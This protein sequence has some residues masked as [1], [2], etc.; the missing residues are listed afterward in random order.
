MVLIRLDAGAVPSRAAVSSSLAEGMSVV[1]SGL[2]PCWV[3]EVPNLDDRSALALSAVQELAR[4]AARR[5]GCFAPFF[6]AAAARAHAGLPLRG[7]FPIET[8][9]EQLARI[10]SLAYSPAE[11]GFL[12]PVEPA[13]ESETVAV[14]AW[15]CSLTGRCVVLCGAPGGSPYESFPTWPG[16]PAS[17]APDDGEG[18]GPVAAPPVRGYPHPLSAAERAVARRLA[19]SQWARGRE[20]N[21]TLPLG[22]LGTEAR[23]DVLWRAERV[24]L[25]V[26]GPEHRR[27]P[28]F[29]GDRRRDTE[30]QLLGYLVIRVTNDEVARDLDSVMDRIER[31]VLAARRRTLVGG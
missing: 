29:S 20:H 18:D 4:D 9:V 1:V 26:D 3:P 7:G 10:V 5:A 31:C 8:E 17:P 24:A 15:M 13:L 28:K 2:Y 11:V 16:G 25:E 12:V 14:A 19:R 23:I 27:E 6:E 30:L 21:V 22:A